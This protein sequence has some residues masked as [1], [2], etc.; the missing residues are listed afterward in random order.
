MREARGAS[1]TKTVR[2][3]IK[4]VL[5][6]GT[7]DGIHD[8]HRYFLREAKKHGDKLAAVISQ[9]AT[10]QNLKGRLPENPLPRRLEELVKEKSLTALSPETKISGTGRL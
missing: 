1:V 2:A 9:D 5:V 10:V 7:F 8:S 4:K 3:K 6:F